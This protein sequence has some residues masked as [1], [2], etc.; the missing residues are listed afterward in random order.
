MQGRQGSSSDQVVIDVNVEETTTGSLG[1]GISFSRAEN[2]GGAVSFSETNFLGR[3]Q[4][5]TAVFNTTSD[6]RQF[7]IDFVEPRVQD[8]ELSAGILL[9]YRETD[10]RDF[11]NFASRQV[12]ISPSVG[13]PVGEF[14]RVNLRYSIESSDIRDVRPEAS[15]LIAADEGREVTS[16]VGVRYTYDTRRSELSPDFGVLVRLD[17][18]IAGLGGDRRFLR[19]T[20]LASVERRVLRGDV[21]VRGELEGGAIHMLSGRSRITERFDLSN[22]MRGFRPG[23]VGP[24]DV[25]SLGNDALGGDYFAVARAEADFPLGLPESLGVAGGVFVDVGSSWGVTCPSNVDCTG[26]RDSVSWR[27]VAGVSLFWETPI[28]PLRFNLSRPLRLEDF[29]ERQNFDVTIQSRF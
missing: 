24:R 20:A 16:L 9:L 15:R 28:G 12:R 14:S 2:F 3:G 4:S 13:F 26:V 1:F 18:E 25:D 10:I 22:R 5:L 23:G 8:R 21:T 19:S 27:A 6:S 17:Q 29:D 7:E 11:A